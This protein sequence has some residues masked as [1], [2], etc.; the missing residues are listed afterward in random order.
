MGS[1][2]DSDFVEGQTRGKAAAV[3]MAT[4]DKALAKSERGRE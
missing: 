4:L 3:L 1:G 2:F